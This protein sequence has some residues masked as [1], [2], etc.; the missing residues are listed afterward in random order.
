MRRRSRAPGRATWATGLSAA[1]MSQ[2]LV[3]HQA[4][5]TLLQVP[6]HPRRSPF[7]WLQATTLEVQ[8]PWAPCSHLPFDILPLS[9][10]GWV[11][12]PDNYISQNPQLPPL[13]RGF[14]S[15]IPQRVH[16]SLLSSG[17]KTSICTTCLSH[18]ST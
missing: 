11:M 8:P 12:D 14:K 17:P 7:P 13:S 10:S 3:L 1:T 5:V 6:P 9:G 2:A 18:D 4:V 15:P 16:G